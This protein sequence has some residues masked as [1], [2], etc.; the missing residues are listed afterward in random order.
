MLAAASLMRLC[1]LENVK[2]LFRGKSYNLKI[3]KSP[4]AKSSL[5]RGEDT[6]ILKLSSLPKTED[7]LVAEARFQVF[8]WLKAEARRYFLLE[9]E[10]ARVAYGFKYKDL[11]VKDTVSRWGSCSA[12]K[13]LNFNW[14][15]VMAPPEILK[16]VVM[17][18]LAHLEHL[19]HS[20]EFWNLVAARYPKYKEAKKWLA[21]KGLELLEFTI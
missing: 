20:T 21:D 8:K 2:I 16:Y 9:V 5:T 18:E 19:N 7:E 10:S 6:I 14:R 11:S 3:T 17:H 4:F 1:D 12:Q 15:L 13:N